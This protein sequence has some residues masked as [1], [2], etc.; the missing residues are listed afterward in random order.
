MKDE[1]K[2]E[3]CNLVSNLLAI[4]PLA[5]TDQDAILIAG[6]DYE[7]QKWFPLPS[8]YTVT[9]AR[10]FVDF[11]NQKRVDGSGLVSAFEYEG[12]FAGVVDIKKADW[13]AQCC[14]IGYWSSPWVRGRGVTSAAL[15]LVSQWILREVGFQRIEVRVAPEN[16]ASQRVAEKAGYVREGTARNAGYTNNGRLDLIIYSRIPSDL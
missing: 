2:F 14:E 4:R 6:N 5:L 16:I 9:N 10:S 13:R 8:P 1:Q 11:S 7:M 3:N 15:I 12:K